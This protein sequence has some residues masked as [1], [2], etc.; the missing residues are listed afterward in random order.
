LILEG[1][2][3]IL[4]SIDGGKVF[5]NPR[6]SFSRSMGVVAVAA[7]SRLKGEKLS[8][9]DVLAATGVRG[10]RYLLE[11]GGVE[12]LHLN[13][14]S[15]IAV[16]V[17]GENLKL[18]GIEGYTTV[19]REDANRFL[20][21]HSVSG[22]RFDFIDI[23][24]YGTPAPFLENAL[25]A[26]ERGGVVAF[27]ATDLA[28]LCG[29]GGRASLRKYGGLPLHNEFC[30]E[31]AARILSYAV[32]QACGRRG[33]YPEILLTVF[34]EHYLRIYARIDLGRD[35]FPHGE[36]GFIYDCPRRH[37]TSSTA[38]MEGRVESTCPLCGSKL[39][40]AGP[41]WLGSLHSKVFLEEMKK[42]LPGLGLGRDWGR[43]ERYLT[44]FE[45]EISLPPY[46]FDIAKA[47]DL[48]GRRTPSP[49]K[50]IEVLEGRG[51]RAARTHF[52]GGGVKTDAPRHVF[53]EAVEE[54]TRL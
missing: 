17:I 43:I 37:Y 3:K 44:L 24:P 54:A 26:V 36:I 4:D 45:G 7:E 35:A 39:R 10:I 28:P 32:V 15:P 19:T 31:T 48:L 42:V 30:H 33:Y 18:N 9:A 8:V 52:K 22:E 41:L 13:D 29:I 6:A 34:S 1:K 16:E 49:L 27:T 20:A 5:Y 53:I 50:V 2:A 25:S 12:E 38:L 51:Y 14:I 47:S 21:S 46:F 40:V 11:S 23:D